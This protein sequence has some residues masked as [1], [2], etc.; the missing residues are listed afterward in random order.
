MDTGK[1]EQDFWLIP[2]RE[3]ADFVGVAGVGCI[4]GAVNGGVWVGGATADDRGNGS[5]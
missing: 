4:G 1:F 3:A 2:R 5:C